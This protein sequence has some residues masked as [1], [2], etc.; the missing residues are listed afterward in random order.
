MIW[1]WRLTVDSVKPDVPRILFGDFQRLLQVLINLLTNAIKFSEPGGSVFVDVDLISAAEVAA[2]R[3]ANCDA[4]APAPD[5][6]MLRFTVGDTGAGIPD[7]D[8]AYI[9][10]RFKQLDS[11]VSGRNQQGLSLSLALSLSLSLSL[12]RSVR[13]GAMRFAKWQP[14]IEIFAQRI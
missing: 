5:G 6:P 7:A 13:L 14:E 10:M 11:G 12:S 9:F 2:L 3:A 1:W 4:K 8:Q